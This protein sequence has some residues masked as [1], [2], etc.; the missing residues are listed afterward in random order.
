MKKNR[1]L[2]LILFL[3]VIAVVSFTSCRLNRTRKKNNGPVD[4]NDK[5]RVDTKKSNGPI[6]TSNWTRVDTT[7]F[8]IKMPNNWKHKVKRAKYADLYLIAPKDGGFNPHLDVTMTGDVGEITMDGYI[9]TTAEGMK[10][11]HMQIDTIGDIIVDDIPGKFII[12]KDVANGRSLAIKTYLFLQNDAAYSL[13]SV[14]LSD[15]STKYFPIFDAEVKTFR[16]K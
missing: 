4:T 7:G 16:I 2:H 1:N 8:S 13:I 15:Q 12:S 11:I 5:A 10:S 9:K 6:D 14:A 3:L